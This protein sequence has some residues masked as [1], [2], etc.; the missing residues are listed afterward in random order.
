MGGPRRA[1][2]SAPTFWLPPPFPIEPWTNHV[3]VHWSTNCQMTITPVGP[4]EVCVALLTSDASLRVQDALSRF[5]EI[6]KRLK[7]APATTTER[8][9]ISALRTLKA[10]S[11]GTVA[12]VGDASG[13][14]DAVTGDGLCLAFRQAAFLA[15]ALSAN[16]LGLY[17]SAP[18]HYAVAGTHVAVDAS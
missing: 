4:T 10:V 15:E 17:Q 13:S 11:C 9:T 2:L 3:E 12:L 8:G 16:N 18:P 14:I 7:G 1:P 6:E 5:P